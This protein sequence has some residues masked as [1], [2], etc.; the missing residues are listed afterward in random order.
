MTVVGHQKRSFG[1]RM[2]TNNLII[3]LTMNTKIYATGQTDTQNV[4]VAT[5]S[6]Y[7]QIV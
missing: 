7:Q 3:S 4:S 6:S 2:K 1:G 5:G